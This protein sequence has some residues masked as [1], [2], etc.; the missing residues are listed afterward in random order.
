MRDP[1]RDLT[2]HAKSFA[3]Q[4]RVIVNE[5]AAA[6]MHCGEQDLLWIEKIHRAAEDLHF[7][8]TCW[9]SLSNGL[10]STEGDRP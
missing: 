1:V 8:L 2:D 7:A 3:D 6:A 5:S 10:R 9:Y 4:A